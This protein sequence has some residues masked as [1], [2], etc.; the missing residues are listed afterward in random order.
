MKR[1]LLLC[2]WFL[3]L[4]TVT[5]GEKEHNIWYFGF[6]AGMDFNSGS[7]VLL[8]NSAMNQWEGCSSICD[9]SGNLLFYT[10]GLSVWNRNHV[11]MANGN[12]L[13]GN[14]SSAQS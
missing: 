11:M 8:T 9:T 6:N 12:G 2:L 4:Y 7:P 5:R 13:L 1:T 14:P 10:S 3:F